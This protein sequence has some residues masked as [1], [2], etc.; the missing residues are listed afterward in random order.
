MQT[1]QQTAEYTVTI[2]Y[3]KQASYKTITFLPWNILSN[4]DLYFCVKFWLFSLCDSSGIRTQNYLIPK[5]K[6]D[7][8]SQFG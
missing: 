4:Q 7:D 3:K 8:L 2:R 6:F 5:R 1:G